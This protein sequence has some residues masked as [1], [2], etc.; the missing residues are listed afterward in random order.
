MKSNKLSIAFSSVALLA[1]GAP[2]VVQNVQAAGSGVLSSDSEEINDGSGVAATSGSAATHD[3]TAGVQ[4]ES[5]D[6][7]LVQVPNFDFGAGN[8]V[9]TKPL[10]LFNADSGSDGSDRNRAAIVVDNRDTE[11]NTA[12]DHSWNLTLSMEEFATADSGDAKINIPMKISG[13]NFSNIKTTID[14][15][16]TP[17]YSVDSGSPSATDKISLDGPSADS[18]VSTVSTNPSVIAS[19]KRFGPTGISFPS[20]DVTLNPTVDNIQSIKTGKVYKSTLNWTLNAD[21]TPGN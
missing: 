8:K 1:V 20:A 3:S 10:N 18:P 21:P 14:S 17:S 19:V 16:G 4:F 9:S 11:A 15:D 7:L 5:G 6:L 2:L 13:V 12:P